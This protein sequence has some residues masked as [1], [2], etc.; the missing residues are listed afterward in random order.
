[1]D[2][3]LSGASAGT[4]LPLVRGRAAARPYPG[5][6]IASIVADPRIL[7]TRTHMEQETRIDPDFP[8]ALLTGD[9][10]RALDPPLR[11]G[12]WELVALV[13]RSNFSLVAEGR[14]IA[15]GRR[16][17]VKICSQAADS[18]RFCREVEYARSINIA[19]V[20]KILDSG[21]AKGG[22]PYHVTRWIEGPTL[23]TFLRDTAVPLDR[24][25]DAVEEL[26]RLMGVLHERGITHRDLK[27]SNA[28]LGADG[29]VE[30]LD[31]GLAHDE[32]RADLTHSGH[33]VGGTRGYFPPWT[34]LDPSL[35]KHHRRQWDVYSLGVMLAGTLTGEWPT[36]EHDP[37]FKPDAARRHL[38]RAL[39]DDRRFD[40]VVARCIADHPEEAFAHAD[41]LYRALRKCRRVNEPRRSRTAVTAVLLV[42]LG[43]GAWYVGRPDKVGNPPA[44]GPVAA[45]NAQSIVSNTPTQPSPNP[46]ILD[47]RRAVVLIN[48][49]PSGATLKIVDRSA[50][51]AV[52]R[53]W[54]AVTNRV[55]FELRSDDAKQYELIAFKFGYRTNT[56]PIGPDS[57][58]INVRLESLSLGLQTASKEKPWPNTLGMP[59]V[60]LPGRGLICV[61]ETRRRDYEV[62]AE[63]QR[64]LNRSW[65]DATYKEQP[66][67]HEPAHP[68]VMVSWEDAKA[69]CAWLTQRERDAGVI[70]PGAEY[71]LPTDADWSLA[72][73]L[74]EAAEGS[75]KDKDRKVGAVYPWGKTWPPPEGAGNLADHATREKLGEFHVVAGYRDG[76]ATTA[77][78]GRFK[79]NAL[80]LHDLAGNVWEWCEDAYDPE[81]PTHRV[82]R[83]GSWNSRYDLTS[84]HRDYQSP[85]YRR[86]YYGFRVI[87]VGVTER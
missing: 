14:S 45:T 70:P 47:L 6:C 56:Q 34:D 23:A 37:D 13:N 12:A 31:L 50:K 76:Y 57:G 71:R 81:R 54:P 59:F 46:A 40:D 43:L 65:R 48:V 10:P 78:V 49:S 55:E 33:M 30:L 51:E 41:E 38:A 87:L 32:Q 2:A 77:P 73:G 15:D 82:L 58:E 4:K 69:F 5:V 3:A 86:A 44:P 29:E 61:Y 27:P 67:G 8:E 17:A 84:S 63:G 28:M 18:E 52:V 64:W 36:T 20:V 35:I 60:P 74:K 62:F 16:V 21:R 1:M 7:A 11:F 39:P 24:R 22:R 75:P 85:T 26:C 83:G 80:G 66:V 79:P 19:G 68:V 25:L 53:E 42:A 72:V 9:S